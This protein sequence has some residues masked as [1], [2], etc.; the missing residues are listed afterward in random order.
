MP[1]EVIQRCSSRKKV[2]TRRLMLQWPTHPS[3]PGARQ[4]TCDRRRSQGNC[5][6][7]SYCCNTITGEGRNHKNTFLFPK[8]HISSSNNVGLSM[9]AWPMALAPPASI[10]T[11]DRLNFPK[12]LFEIFIYVLN[13]GFQ[14][15]KCLNM[16]SCFQL[17]AILWYMRIKFQIYQVNT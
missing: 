14:L 17:E 9:L 11:C 15:H 6:R 8:H 4:D 12:Q 1:S 2:T 10:T 16:V 7:G 5:M 13:D 3:P